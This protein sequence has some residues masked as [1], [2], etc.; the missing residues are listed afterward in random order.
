MGRVSRLKRERR[1][2]RRDVK[3][4]LVARVESR[5]RAGQ[6]PWGP[7]R[8]GPK[9]S[10][11]LAALIQPYTYDDME[12]EAR[13]KLVCLGVM[14]WNY[15]VAPATL[16]RERIFSAPESTGAAEPERLF[17]LIEEL[18]QR[19]LR[20]FA[21]DRRLILDAEL[22]ELSDGSFYIAAAAVQD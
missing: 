6:L 22:R 10:D 2:L 7:L 11:G 16:S 8:Q 9:I 4:E 5:G 1:V 12:I 19:K 13:R 21:D 18:A 17:Q 3:S 14:A 20:D 15:A